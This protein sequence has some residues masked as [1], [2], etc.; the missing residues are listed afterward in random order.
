MK[1]ESFL[2]KVSK[3]LTR[4]DLKSNPWFLS[5]NPNVIY[6]ISSKH[7]WGGMI[8]DGWWINST[9]SLHIKFRFSALAW[10]IN[11]ERKMQAIHIPCLVYDTRIH[12]DETLQ[13]FSMA[14]SVTIFLIRRQ[15]QN[16]YQQGIWSPLYRL[17]GIKKWYE[18]TRGTSWIHRI[19]I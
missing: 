16:N 13:L 15:M 6:F 17:E 10:R 2:S 11:S 7:K 3:Q 1:T 8:H 4:L 18:N 5:L 19:L 12:A 14:T 9:A